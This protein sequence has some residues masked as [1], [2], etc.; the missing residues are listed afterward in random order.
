MKISHL[1]KKK[2][3]SGEEI[4]GQEIREGIFNLI[5]A[6]YSDFTKEDY[7]SITELNKFRRLYLTSLIT[8]ESGELAILDKDVMD[9]INNNSILSENI[10]DEIEAELTFGQRIADKVAAFGYQVKEFFSYLNL[11]D[12]VTEH[13]IAHFH[14]WMAGLPI[15]GIRKDKLNIKIVFTTHATLLG[16]LLRLHQCLLARIQQDWHQ[17]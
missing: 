1:S 4:Q 11:A 8:E 3:S 10:Q 16:Q 12:L 17:N 14:E 15:P 5:R 6:T 13:V 9:A 2:I 7:I